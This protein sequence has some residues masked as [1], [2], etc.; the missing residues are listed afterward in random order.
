SAATLG[1][2]L[3]GLAVVF[4]YM[5]TDQTARLV[6]AAAIAVALLVLM[7]LYLMFGN[8]TVLVNAET[9]GS[10]VIGAVVAIIMFI[11]VAPAE[12]PKKK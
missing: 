12:A 9:L 3:V 8:E 7:R 10:V 4:L 2:A 11:K 6:Q 1:A 5:A